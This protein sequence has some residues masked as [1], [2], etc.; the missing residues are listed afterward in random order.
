MERWPASA[1]CLKPGCGEGMVGSFGDTG[2]EPWAQ[3]LD[4]YTL[5]AKICQ[6]LP[7]LNMKVVQWSIIWSVRG[8]RVPKQPSRAVE[9]P[10]SMVGDKLLSGMMELPVSSRTM[11]RFSAT[12]LDLCE[13]KEP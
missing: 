1:H 4:S 12:E 3:D 8:S 13:V 11:R 10:K 2:H 7:A 6:T 9:N 5:L